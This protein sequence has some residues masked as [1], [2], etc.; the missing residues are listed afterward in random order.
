MSTKSNL[1]LHAVIIEKPVSLDDA[2]KIAAEIIKDSSK[3]FYRETESSYRFRNIP[4]T[5]F[6]PDSYV[7]KIIKK[8]PHTTLI[9]GKLKA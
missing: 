4:K 2:K 1:K 9:F 8:K 3:T 5:K 6:N 7:S